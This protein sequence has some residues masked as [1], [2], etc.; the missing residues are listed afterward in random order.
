ME[1]TKFVAAILAAARLAK[2]KD[3]SPEQAA[4]YFVHAVAVGQDQA[5][6]AGAHANIGPAGPG[7]GARGPGC[8]RAALVQ[9]VDVQPATPFHGAA[10]AAVVTA[11]PV[12][13]HYRSPSL[14][15]SGDIAVMRATAEAAEPLTGPAAARLD[16]ALEEIR[17]PDEL[18]A[19]AAS[20]RLA[21][22]IAAVPA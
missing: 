8:Q 13:A 7:D 10:P 4:K 12:A 9:F 19:E 1:D 20:A 2:E 5:V 15:C 16:R 3:Q 18:D 21:E 6:V 11:R 14:E 22:M 17:A